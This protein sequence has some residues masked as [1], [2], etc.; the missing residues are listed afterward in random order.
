[1]YERQKF[2]VQLR[3][4]MKKENVRD[5]PLKGCPGTVAKQFIFHGSIWLVG[6]SPAWELG[7]FILPHLKY[8]NYSELD[9][10]PAFGH[11]M[12]TS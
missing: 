5:C 4:V 8:F 3:A 1:M 7:E 9:E 12:K 6:V 10:S 2:D 11:Y